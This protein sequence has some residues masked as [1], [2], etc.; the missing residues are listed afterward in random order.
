MPANT[1]TC[2]D[3]M[4]AVRRRADMEN[5]TFV[6]EPEIRSYINVAMAELHDIL[7]QKFEDYYI[8]SSTTYTLPISGNKG[9]LPDSFYKMLGVDFAAGGSTYRVRPYKFQERNMYGKVA[10]F[11]G[12]ANNLTY[13]VQGNE[14]HFKPADALPS[15]IITIHFVPQADQF[16]TDGSTDSEQLSLNN[17]AI[18]PGYEEYIVIDAAIKCLLKE[19]SDVSV[20]MAQRESA[21]RRIEE[22]AGKRDAG[23]PYAIS[24]VTTGTAISD[25]YSR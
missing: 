16:A 19:E 11:S 25:F 9:T 21:R 12:I 20:H 18:A 7:V 22:A 4:T 8:D 10:T 5:S 23:E 1:I 3:L 2:A 15:G 14:I 6:T 13:H 24:D 17:R